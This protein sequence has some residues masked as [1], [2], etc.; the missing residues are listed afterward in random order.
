MTSHANHYKPGRLSRGFKNT[1]ALRSR[2]RAKLS[3][4]G[5][6]FQTGEVTP[7]A[8]SYTVA[9]EQPVGE[10]SQAPRKLVRIVHAHACAGGRGLE[11]PALQS[12]DA[13]LI[14]KAPFKQAAP[15]V[16]GDD[17]GVGH[18]LP[19]QPPGDADLQPHLEF[20]SA[21]LHL[22]LA[23]HLRAVPVGH[24]LRHKKDKHTVR[25]RSNLHAEFKLGHW[26]GR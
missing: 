13:V 19:A 21:V 4:L 25:R 18:F 5:E 14:L 1:G 15:L 7:I 11:F 2:R 6:F 3:A 17:G 23:L 12:A 9:R 22:E 10:A 20:R 16:A 8:A 24:A 26:R